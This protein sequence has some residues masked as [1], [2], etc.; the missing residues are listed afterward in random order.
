MCDETGDFAGTAVAI[1]I[2]I[3][4]VGLLL[5]GTA[6]YGSTIGQ[7]L[8]DICH[9]IWVA[10]E[11]TV[12]SF[13]DT[14][15]DKSKEKEKENKKKVTVIY[16]YGEKKNS[17][18]YPSKNDVSSNTCLS[19]STM[20]NLLGPN[21]MTTIETVNETKVLYAVQDGKT[22]VSVC[23][24]GGTIEQWRN[25]RANSIW[26]QALKSIVVEWDGLN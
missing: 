18:L 21:M 2:G 12:D 8:A 25:E 5:Y 19:F 24:V 10:L 15:E 14:K 11:T 9:N 7:G 13:K 26:T 22:H 3:T 17:N 1:G 16:R 4:V 6:K 20:P 23:P